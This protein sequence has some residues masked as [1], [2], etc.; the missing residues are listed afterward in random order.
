[1][2][3]VSD[4]VADAAGDI[5]G[6]LMQHAIMALSIAALIFFIHRGWKAFKGLL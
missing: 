4:V 1:M 2:I 5:L 6:H 3:P